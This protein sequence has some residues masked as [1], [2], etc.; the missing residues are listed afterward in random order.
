MPQIQGF[1]RV[2]NRE[3][4]NYGVADTD[5]VCPTGDY[6]KVAYIKV[7]AQSMMALGNGQIVSGVDDRGY[8]QVLLHSTAGA[9]PG[10]VRI[11]YTNNSG[12][13]VKII[14]EERTENISTAN[15]TRLGEY[16]DL[17]AKQDSYLVIYFNPDS[18]TT[19][20]ASDTTNKI[21]LPT[22]VYQ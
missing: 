17:K 6:T 1:R 16:L 15:T 18:T 4:L 20:D 12:T 7:T 5:I 3:D 22:T 11:G 19:L 21:L 10:L 8:A 13:N 2:L 9:V 14:M